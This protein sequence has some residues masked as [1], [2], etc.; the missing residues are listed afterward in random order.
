MTTLSFDEIQNKTI[1]WCKNLL[2]NGIY[3][4]E[5]Y[6]KCIESF[7]RDSSGLMDDKFEVPRTGIE[8]NFGLYNR[9]KEY[10]EDANPSS[11]KPTVMITSYDGKYLGVRE[12]G[13]LYHVTDYNQQGINQQ[14]LEWSVI[15]QGDNKFSIMSVANQKY[16]NSDSDDNV[17]CKSDNMNPNS[18]WK[19]TQLENKTL[20]ESISKPDFY[21]SYNEN[22]KYCTSLDKGI[23]DNKMWNMFNLSQNSENLVPEYDGTEY[24]NKK[25][26][27]FDNYVMSKKLNKI[28]STEILILQEVIGIV[29]SA[30]ENINR[31]IESEYSKSRE[32]INKASSKY[33]KELGEIDEYRRQLTLPG[34]S[35]SMF[36]TYSDTIKKLEKK[37]GLS[38]NSMLTLE[39]KIKLLKEIDIQKKK[40][41]AMLTDEIKKRNRELLNLK[42]M[43]NAEGNVDA[44]IRD[45][46]YEVDLVDRQLM[47]NNKIMSRQTSEMN[48]FKSNTFSKKEK[49]NK[50][51]KKKD[52]IEEN[53]NFLE[54]RYKNK[55]KII[56]YYIAGIIF[57]ILLI[58]L[59]S[60]F[61]YVNIKSVYF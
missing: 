12:N 43:K 56:Y 26:I 27:L 20:L 37:I 15:S 23:S 25:T 22:N 58:A 13:L 18:T 7:R 4:I 48:K 60:Y 33:L 1:A 2:D 35:N 38:K 52:I 61:L 28:I 14:E 29:R 10:L 47:N 51:S 53:N 31:Y 24:K 42:R 45:M 39:N 9:E 57:L 55:N 40:Y 46:N 11:Y 3:S 17:V 49:L 36:S 6:N 19:F 59:I 34:T 44:L 50:L 41:I 54:Q 30:F 5:D 21:I 8:Y 16:I 32:E